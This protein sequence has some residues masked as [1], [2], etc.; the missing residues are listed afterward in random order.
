MKK[1]VEEKK[2]KRYIRGALR[3][4]GVKKNKTSQKSTEESCNK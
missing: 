2:R 1:E 3:L 4:L